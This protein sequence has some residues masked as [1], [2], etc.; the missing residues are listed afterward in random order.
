MARAAAPCR[1]PAQPYSILN[2][3]EQFAVGHLLCFWLSHIRG[4]RVRSLSH[5]RVAGAIVAVANGAM[6]GPMG[7]ALRENLGSI[8]YGIGTGASIGGKRRRSGPARHPTLHTGRLFGRAE[9]VGIHN[10]KSCPCGGN[11]T[12]RDCPK[13]KVSEAIQPFD[14]TSCRKATDLGQTRDHCH[15]LD[16]SGQIVFMAI[17][18]EDLARYGIVLVPPSTAEYFELLADIEQR[19]QNRPAGSPPIKRDAISRIA[20]HDTSGSAILLNR[21]QVAIASIAYI[22]S[23][24]GRRDGRLSPHSFSPGTNPSV[25]LPF[26]L[27]DRIRKV[28]AFWNTILPGS[29]RLITSDGSSF[30]D[31]TDVRP[32]AVDELWHGS[33]VSIGGGSGSHESQPVKLTLDGI[34]FVDGGFAG[35]NRLGAWEHTVFAAEAYLNCAA[36]AQEASRHGTPPAEFFTEVQTLTG[37]MDE[38]MPPPPHRPNLE[39]AAPDPEPIRTYQLQVVGGRVLAMRKRLGDEAAMAA[40]EAWADAPVPKFYRL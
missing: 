25:L 10:K 9:S 16:K 38:R 40:V 21:A 27:D 20:E 26:G 34:F 32:P 13:Q 14:H 19:L 18:C 17:V 29:K 35:P 7:P 6:I 2:D 22:W 4:G 30:G 33:F 3:V 1:H 39:S 31:N 12:D 24:S 11:N 8:G 37:Q 36:L 5:L 15:R 28:R 23:F